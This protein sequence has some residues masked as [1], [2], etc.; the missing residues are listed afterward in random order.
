MPPIVFVQYLWLTTVFSEDILLNSFITFA[1]A[2][3]RHTG[4]WRA[5]AFIRFFFITLQDLLI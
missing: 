3:L 5:E 1:Y 4:G 2:A